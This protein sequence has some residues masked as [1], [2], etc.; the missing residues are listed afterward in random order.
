MTAKE[1]LHRRVDDLT[2]DEALE[3]LRMLERQAQEP[4]DSLAALLDAAP[5]DDEP[6][7][8]EDDELREAREQA[9][10]GEGISLEQARAEL[11]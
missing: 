5:L 3:A 8:L 9:A 1:Q 7:E 11:G 6:P 2:E 4:G 10:R